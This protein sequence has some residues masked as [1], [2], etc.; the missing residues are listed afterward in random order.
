M[1]KQEFSILLDGLI[2]ECEE[3]GI[4]TMTP[5]EVSRLSFIENVSNSK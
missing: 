5:N 3:C 1:N 4:S 2:S